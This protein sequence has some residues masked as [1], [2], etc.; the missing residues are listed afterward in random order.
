MEVRIIPMS[1][2]DEEFINMSIKDIQENFFKNTL[3]NVSKGW[4]YY[5]EKGLDANEGDLLLFQMDNSIIASA[6]LDNIIRFLKPT[7]EGNTGALVL[8][9]KSIKTFDP[10]SKTEL[11]EFIHQF[12]SFNQVKQRFNKEEVNIEGLN[13][14]MKENGCS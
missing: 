1:L 2:C 7:I 8:D 4:Y 11:K 12:N 6:K 14:R 10:I 9:C 3:I 5:G 13:E